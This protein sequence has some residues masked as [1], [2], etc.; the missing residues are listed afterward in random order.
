MAIR[1]L[2]RAEVQT[3]VDWAAGEGWNPG[4]RDADAFFAADPEGFL[5]VERDG[6][7]IG[8]ISAVRYG[9]DYGFIGFYIMAEGHRMTIDGIRLGQA[10]LARLKGRRIGVDGVLAKAP[11]YAR[12]AGFRHAWQNVRYQGP[13]AA[14]RR[15]GEGGTA[16]SLPPGL[17]LRPAGEL[18]FDQLV[19]YDAHHFGA[20]RDA[21]LREW[22]SLPG[23]QAWVCMATDG[24]RDAV[25]AFGVI[26]ACRV[27]S[28]VGPLFAADA[29]VAE[30]LFRRLVSLA[31]DGPI[32]LDTPDANPAAVALAERYGMTPVFATARM[33]SG[34]DPGLPLAAIFG[35]TSFELG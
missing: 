19:A 35:V 20:R 15:G 4:L 11:Q 13:V 25:R 10:G 3:A 32:V 9:D 31:A 23:H 24:R 26:R 27:G 28:K 2:T 34:G 30:A 1:M 16:P 5:G 29:V 8:T 14:V 21:F 33:Y 17:E 12:L 7:L 18:P 6:E 22:I